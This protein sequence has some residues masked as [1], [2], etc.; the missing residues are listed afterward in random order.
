MLSLDEPH[1]Y[2]GGRGRGEGRGRGG[3][4]AKHIYSHEYVDKG[5]SVSESSMLCITGGAQ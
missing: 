5:L 1:H 3:K 4:V 2:G